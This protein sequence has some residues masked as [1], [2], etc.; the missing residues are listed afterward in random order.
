M[1]ASEVTT[2]I[3]KLSEKLG[4]AA[5]KMVIPIQ[6]GIEAYQVTGMRSVVMAGIG[7]F[8][9]VFAMAMLTFTIVKVNGDDAVGCLGILS[10]GMGLIGILILVFH[11]PDAGMFLY[12][13]EKYA[14]VKLMEMALQAH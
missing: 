6:K 13:P 12:S 2:V 4:V 5:D 3:D 7:L 9:A 8:L 1:T 11:A 10:V 14:I